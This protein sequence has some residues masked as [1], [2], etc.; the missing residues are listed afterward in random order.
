MTVVVPRAS[1]TGTRTEAARLAPDTVSTAWT[2]VFEA[3]AMATG[4]FAE[5]EVA[6]TMRRVGNAS[7]D[8]SWAIAVSGADR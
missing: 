8:L 5:E 2:G 3:D 7:F 4:N 1:T 6:V